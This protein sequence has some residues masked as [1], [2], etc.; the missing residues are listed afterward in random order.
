MDGDE[1]LL[2][3]AGW[4]CVTRTGELAMGPGEVPWAAH[5]QP[6][7]RY[8]LLKLSIR[9]IVPY[10]WQGG[11]RR[12]LGDACDRLDEQCVPCA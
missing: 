9:D 4:V 6:P 5:A 8:R 10:S 3:G 11:R 7:G 12:A 1:S 2:D